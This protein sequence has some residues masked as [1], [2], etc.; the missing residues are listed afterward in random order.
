M[1]QG[2]CWGQ[3]RESRGDT[4]GQDE[5]GGLTHEGARPSEQVSE[6]RG[7]VNRGGT[8]P[9]INGTKLG[10]GVQVE[11]GSGLILGSSDMSCIKLAASSVLRLASFCDSLTPS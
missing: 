10:K 11:W 2:H 4:K 3:K 1:L 8:T 5:E 7:K 6:R 9:N